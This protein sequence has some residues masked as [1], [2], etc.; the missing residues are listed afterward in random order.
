MSKLSQ[1]PYQSRRL[2][3]LTGTTQR[4]PR[5][6]LERR[7]E[8][9]DASERAYGSYTSYLANTTLAATKKKIADTDS[10]AK[11]KDTDLLR[12]AVVDK[13]AS[14]SAKARTIAMDGVASL[15]TPLSI[16]PTIVALSAPFARA[17]DYKWHLP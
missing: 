15:K 10:E 5:L 7:D 16:W 14:A 3:P 12:D 17:P 9:S 4:P 6:S 1:G 2:T 11:I 8:L 13:A